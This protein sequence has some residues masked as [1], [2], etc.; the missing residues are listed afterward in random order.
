MVSAEIE[1]DNADSAAT[2]RA[3]SAERLIVKV[4]SAARAVKVSVRM[5]ASTCPNLDTTSW[6]DEPSALTILTFSAPNTSSCAVW[7]VDELAFDCSLN[8]WSFSSPPNKLRVF[9]LELISVIVLKF[10]VFGFGYM[11]GKK[12]IKNK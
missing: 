6:M 3:V 1:A 10:K 9:D 8:N 2:D 11:L 5:S 4:D 12:K 7:R